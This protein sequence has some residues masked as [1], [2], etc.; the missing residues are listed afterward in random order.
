M[1]SLSQLSVAWHA[2]NC[3]ESDGRQLDSRPSSL[4]ASSKR[5]ARTLNPTQGAPLAL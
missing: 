4:M 2:K 1:R 5:E 3:Q